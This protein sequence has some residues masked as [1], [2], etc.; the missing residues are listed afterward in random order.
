MTDIKPHQRINDILLAPL[1]KPALQWLVVRLPGWISPD[2][3]TF[4]G[5]LG[6]VMIFSSYCLS[7]KYPELLWLASLGFVVNWFG[8][9]LDGNLARYRTLASPK[10]YRSAYRFNGL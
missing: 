8:D 6:A 1:E 9:S 2:I 7:N 4:I 10:G 3:L 5:I